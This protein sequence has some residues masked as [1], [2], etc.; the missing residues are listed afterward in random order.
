M[1]NLLA[2]SPKP[3]RVFGARRLQMI[4]DEGSCRVT[5]GEII[6]RL[7]VPQHRRY[8]VIPSLPLHKANEGRVLVRA[9]RRDTVPELILD[10]HDVSQK[11]PD[12]RNT[13]S[14]DSQK[15]S[16]IA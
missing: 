5:F 4:L 14:F 6:W 12:E 1:L 7:L 13:G 2:L 15:K 11:H 10:V 3:A 9:R 8:Y 16:A